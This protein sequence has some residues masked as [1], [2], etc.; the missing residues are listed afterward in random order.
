MK[1]RYDA[2]ADYS[3]FEKGDT[4]CLYNLQRKK[5]CLPSSADLVQDHMS[6][7]KGLMI[8]CIGF[9]RDRNPK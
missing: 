2:E 4:V 5:E 7:S 6:S 1:R 8:W 3:V 9:S